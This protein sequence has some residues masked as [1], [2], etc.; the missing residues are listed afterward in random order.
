VGNYFGGATFGWAAWVGATIG[1][2]T[3][4]RA[5]FGRT[6]VGFG[7]VAPAGTAAKQQRCV[8]L[9]T[10]STSASRSLAIDRPCLP[11][12][13]ALPR[14]SLPRTTMTT[15]VQHDRFS[16]RRGFLSLIAC[17]VFLTSIGPRSLLAQDSETD[18]EAPIIEHEEVTSGKLGEVQTFSASVVDNQELVSVLLFHRFD[19]TEDFQQIQMEPLA[20]SSFFAARVL[21]ADVDATRIEYYFKAEDAAGNISLKGFTFDPLVRTLD[22]PPGQTNDQTAEVEQVPA[23][24]ETT[25][26]TRG[27]SKWLYYVLGALAVGGIAAFAVTSGSDD[28][29]SSGSGSNECGVD[30]CRIMLQVPVP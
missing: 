5:A 7:Q 14:V 18:F 22:A 15:R 21:T 12:A 17:S 30:G 10:A 1:R 28:G 25:E 8:G 16:I 3:V 19:D 23:T 26:P 9:R 2:A 20:E 13:E 27:K 24:T 4:G 6:A 11:A 29:G